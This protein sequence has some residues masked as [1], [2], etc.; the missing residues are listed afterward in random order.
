MERSVDELW[1]QTY[2]RDYEPPDNLSFIYQ[3]LGQY[4]KALAESREALRL[5]PAS[6][7]S[8]AALVYSYV[9]A[10]RLEEAR[11]TAKE[12]L[13]KN[14]DCLA[15]RGAMYA[16]AF[17]QND[18]AGMAEQIAKMGMTTGGDADTA[19]YFGHLRKARELSRQATASW[20]QMKLK[21]IAAGSEAQAALREALFGNPVEA[22]QRAVAALALSTGRDV[23]FGAAL[24]LAFAGDGARA[25]ALADDLGKRFPEDTV[26]QFNYLP[27][28]RAQLALNHED[29]SKSIEALQVA[30]RYELGCPSTGFAPALY[31]VYVRAQA[32][33]AGRH[34]EGHQ[35]E[36]EFQKILDHRGLVAND[37]IGALAHLGLAR[38]YAVQN[39]TPKAR[40]AYNDF[41]VL[42]KDADCDIPILTDAKVEYA[43]LK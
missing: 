30:T 26:V 28:L 4:D 10:N 42:W 5:N 38:A 36:A 2:P 33:L 21:E 3:Q 31:P 37:P 6:A 27:T 1:A 35:A 12:A 13:A 20:V 11:A 43:R 14:L 17:L 18:A 15:L 16:L 23:Q 40:A 34:G 7:L 25:G 39:D 9:Y 41:F 24:A 32:Y 19:A 8:Y 22:Q 29:T